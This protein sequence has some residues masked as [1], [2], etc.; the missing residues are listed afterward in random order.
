MKVNGAKFKAEFG[1]KPRMLMPDKVGERA[2][3]QVGLDYL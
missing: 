3:H 2:G 1:I